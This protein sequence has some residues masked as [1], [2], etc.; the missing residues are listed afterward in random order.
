M[1]HS[2]AFDDRHVVPTTAEVTQTAHRAGLSGQRLFPSRGLN[3]GQLIA[4]VR[5]S[6]FAPLVG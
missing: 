1:L 5:D 3:F 6:G 4:T 2:S